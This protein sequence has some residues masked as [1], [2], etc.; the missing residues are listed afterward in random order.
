LSDP[1]LKPIRD[2]KIALETQQTN[3]VKEA[4][5]QS[6]AEVERARQM[7]AQE[8]AKVEA[9]TKL[10]VGTIEQEV[11]NTAVR[12]AAEI[13]KMK[14][15]YAARIALLDSQ[16]TRAL[17]EAEANAKKLKETAKSSLYQLKMSVFQSD[18]NA[19]LRSALAEQL[20]PDMILRFFHSGTG[21]L[22]TNMDSKGM[23]PRSY[24]NPA[25]PW[26]RRNRLLP[27]AVHLS[28]PWPVRRT[29]RWQ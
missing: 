27:Q 25:S 5:A 29:N 22:W 12:N 18:A 21:T 6:A 15:D 28:R 20:N 2:S 10:L 17:G 13:E 23:N 4:T 7:I 1:Y 14:A 19:F 11:D 8:V 26:R 24:G 9:Q 16:R 3:H